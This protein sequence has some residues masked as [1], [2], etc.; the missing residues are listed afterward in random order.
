MADAFTGMTPVTLA[1]WQALVPEGNTQINMMIQTIRD[2]QAFFDRATLVRGNDGQGKKGL[3]GEKYPEGQLVG[4]N[5][6]WSASNAAGRAVR[7]PSCTARDRSVIAKNMLEKMPDKERNAFRMRTD[8]MFIK[9]LTRGMVK[10]VFQGNPATDPRDC[11]G[12]A[13][14]VLPDRDNGVWKDFQSLMVAAQ[15]Q[16]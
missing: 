14:I 11:M 15:V 16:N 4:M 13:N 5:E 7:Y 3:V 6:G 9:G 1:E 12:L 2:Y 8:Q 10:R